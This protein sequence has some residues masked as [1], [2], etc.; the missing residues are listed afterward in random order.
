MIAYAKGVSYC[1]IHEELLT[2]VTFIHHVHP[3]TKQLLCMCSM[4]GGALDFHKKPEPTTI[5]GQSP[6]ESDDLCNC[7]TSWYCMIVYYVP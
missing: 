7:E 1:V 6:E 5:Q 4:V 2:V 3:V